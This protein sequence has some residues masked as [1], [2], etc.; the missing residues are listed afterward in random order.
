MTS[1]FLNHE[2]ATEL[3][4]TDDG[5]AYSLVAQ[6]T[7]PSSSCLH[8]LHVGSRHNFPVLLSS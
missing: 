1:S 4:P 6:H 3:C 7:S 2:D 8:Y 5:L